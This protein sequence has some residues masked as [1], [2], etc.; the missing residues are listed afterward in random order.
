MNLTP[1][2][3]DSELKRLRQEIRELI[4][5]CA[6]CTSK[7]APEEQHTRMILSEIRGVWFRHNRRCHTCRT[8]G[9]SA[10]TAHNRVIMRLFILS[11]AIL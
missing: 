8:R 7:M 3:V 2:I 4:T 1:N 11:G 6:H 9:E 5:S 10:M